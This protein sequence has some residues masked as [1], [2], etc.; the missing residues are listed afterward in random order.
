[1]SSWQLSLLKFIPKLMRKSSDSVEVYILSY[2][3]PNEDAV[4]FIER[5]DSG[6]IRKR[7]L[8][9]PREIRNIVKQQ[10]FRFYEI[11]NKY[12]VNTD[13]G[14]LVEKEDLPDLSNIKTFSIS[15]GSTI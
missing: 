9:V 14:R 3:I 6:N 10:R 5:K 4:F 12:T 7:Y 11:I 8:I 1:M 13:I 15:N 2:S